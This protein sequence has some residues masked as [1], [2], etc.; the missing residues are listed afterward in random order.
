[1]LT[2]VT[3]SRTPAGRWSLIRE[4]RPINAVSFYLI[5]RHNPLIITEGWVCGASIPVFLS[6]H[7][8]QKDCQP[9]LKR[10][11]LPMRLDYP[12]LDINPV[13]RVLRDIIIIII[14]IIIICISFNYVLL[15]QNFLA[16]GDDQWPKVLDQLCMFLSSII[17][18]W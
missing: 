13:F 14:I 17:Y 10:I 3:M 8:L 6:R 1:M 11:P 7:H 5:T 18:F 4:S 2:N 9:R 15:F 16:L 12:L